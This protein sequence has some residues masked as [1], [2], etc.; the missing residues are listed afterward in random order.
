V[1]STRVLDFSIEAR[2]FQE[3]TTYNVGGGP[4]AKSI[5]SGVANL[6]AR[7]VELGDWWAELPS[8]PDVSLAPGKLYGPRSWRRPPL[9]RVVNR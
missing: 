4:I 5:A 8:K 3:G 7:E 6:G 9:D 1:L 2:K